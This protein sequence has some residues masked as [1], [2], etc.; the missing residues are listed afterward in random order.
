M[1]FNPYLK[2]GTD[3]FV[4]HVPVSDFNS[5]FAD[6]FSFSAGLTQQSPAGDFGVIRF[7]RILVNDGGHYNS[8]TGTQQGFVA[9][10]EFDGSPTAVYINFVVLCF[11]LWSSGTR[12]QNVP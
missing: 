1:H 3:T 11:F 5:A 7:N 8:H 12:F 2:A 4:F 10:D 9:C 6:P